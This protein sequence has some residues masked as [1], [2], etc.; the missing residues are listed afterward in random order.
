[1]G[2]PSVKR[3]DGNPK[4][5]P[6]L[7]TLDIRVTTSDEDSTSDAG[8]DSDA[9]TV[10]ILDAYTPVHVDNTVTPRRKL[11]VAPASPLTGVVSAT[12]EPA[13][14][15]AYRRRSMP[16]HP[17]SVRHD[18]LA[19]L[20][21]ETRACLNDIPR[22]NVDLATTQIITEA[23]DGG[24]T[25]QG[26][27]AAKTAIFKKVS[28][29]YV[30]SE[31]EVADAVLKEKNAVLASR[32]PKYEDSDICLQHEGPRVDAFASSD[33][34]T[35]APKLTPVT[36]PLAPAPTHDLA[37]FTAALSPAPP[38]VVRS[39][40]QSSINAERKKYVAQ[41]LHVHLLPRPTPDTRLRQFVVGRDGDAVLALARAQQRATCPTE[42]DVMK[43]DT[44]EPL[45]LMRRASAV[46]AALSVVSVSVLTA[47][48]YALL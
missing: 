29:V 3:E 2:C 5:K 35:E 37:A 34:D 47:V 31:N 40:A 23:S 30:S 26:R 7:C 41:G 43:P 6:K 24:A 9:S 32:L 25:L 15:R 1:V 36:R 20:S 33:E 28:L 48:G 39:V 27:G 45:S 8:G 4:L 12:D 22:M 11:G 16:P 19:S 46:T 38:A 18:T 13:S 42:P 14:R 44:M 17:L 21:S 10:V